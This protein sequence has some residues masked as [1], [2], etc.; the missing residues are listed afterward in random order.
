MGKARNLFKEALIRE[1]KIEKRV[2]SYLDLS[3]LLT[4]FTNTFSAPPCL[5]LGIKK[6]TFFIYKI[7]GFN[8]KLLGLVF[9]EFL[10]Q[11]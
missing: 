10:L 5:R 4:R 2:T 6:I 1:A 3:K 7:S 8:L 9:L 11:I